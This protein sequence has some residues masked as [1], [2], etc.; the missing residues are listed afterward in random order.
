MQ[1]TNEMYKQ[2]I[3]QLLL[4]HS[5]LTFDEIMNLLNIV[6]NTAT[7]KKVIKIIANM[8]SEHEIEFLSNGEIQLVKKVEKI[9]QGKYR[10]NSKGFGFVTFDLENN[11]EV[12]ISRNNA[13][14]ALDGDVV[15]VELM[16]KQVDSK[17][18]E[19]QIIEIIE[20]GAITVVGQF[21]KYHQELQNKTG[22]Y[23]YVIPQNKLYA[24]LTCFISG[25][26][27][28]VDGTVCVVEI[29]NYPTKENPKTLEGLIIK[30]VGFKD[31]PGV[32]ILSVLYQKNIPT[33]FPHAVLEEANQIPLTLS[34]K[35]L[36]RRLDLRQEKIFTIDGADAKDLDD[37]VSIKIL[38]NGHYELGVHIAD[39]SHYVVENS[40]L[41]KEAY[42]RATSVY[43]VDRVVPM[44]PQRLSNGICSL[45]PYEDRLTMS[46][47]M[48]INSSGEVINYCIKKSVINSKKRMTYDDV[49]AVLIEGNKAIQQDYAEFIDSLE[50]MR[51]LHY[52][53]YHKRYKRGAIDFE[54]NESKIVVDELGVPF[55]VVLRE[56]GLSQRM[57]ESFMLVANE[58]VAKHY[59][60]K[61]YPFI[62]R[63]HEKPD[64]EKIQKFMEIATNFGILMKGKAIQVKTKDLQKVL[65]NIED[66]PYEKIVSTILL[67]SMKQAKYDNQPLGHFGLATEYYT[68]FT[69]PIRR[70]PDL[71][72]HRFI[73]KY[74]KK[75]LKR[76]Y[77]TLN[78]Q[79]ENIAHQSSI[80]E[81]K[82]VEAERE[83][84]SMKKTE[85]MLD[86]IG[87]QFS[88]VISSVTRFGMFVELDNTI[89]GLVH[90]SKMLDDHYEFIENQIMLLGQRT[91]K[92]YQL[93]QKVNIIV[94]K[95]DKETREIDFELVDMQQDKMKKVNH[96][97][98]IK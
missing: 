97:V 19:G 43:L 95:V 84:E 39:V 82:S 63:V 58:T 91:G 87:Q 92:I 76:D 29:Q 18:L 7:M 50:L 73:K 66:K 44:L 30:N 14:T 38:D 69:S 88:G 70:Y 11:Q 4:E 13:L 52:A 8:E 36:S 55:D 75:P 23:G 54:I 25:G 81:R 34:K 79:L 85:F 71:I 12:Y 83:V 93:G 41:D 17:S 42:N 1:I 98:Q 9:V 59:M 53:L 47:I 16:D 78:E 62:Y 72:V 2:K 21:V 33:E 49:N 56:R 28:A 96:C 35:D 48:E 80:M 65:T 20:R 26:L 10:Y 24:H 31:E 6:I 77:D 37:A 5:A 45:H 32:D 46:C 68:H 67:R 89:E 40:E 51:D 3:K 61:K 15:K 90:I 22:Y 64:S 74:S 60:D 86:K 27:E 94:A 57:I